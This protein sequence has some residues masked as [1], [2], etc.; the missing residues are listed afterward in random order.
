MLREVLAAR[1]LALATFVVSGLCVHFRSRE[2][3]RLSRQV[4]DHSSWLPTAR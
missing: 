3:P 1:H 4:L 2:R